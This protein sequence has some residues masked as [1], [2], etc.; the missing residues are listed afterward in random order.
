MNR[1]GLFDLFDV[2]GSG[3]VDLN[4]LSAGLSVL[5]GGGREEKVEA[6]FAMF[7]FDGNGFIDLDEMTT[8]L[9]SVFKVL[10]ATE[11]GTEEKMGVSSEEL[12][13]VTAEQ[14]FE[15][16]DADGDGRISL[17]EFKAWYA[18]PG[19]SAGFMKP[20]GGGGH[21]G[22]RRSGPSDYK[23]SFLH[24]NHKWNRALR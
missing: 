17:E 16:A 9:S 18:Q 3:A 1:L 12:A 11:P 7:D 10:Y 20:Q 8:Y 5:C 14:A 24:N 19:G 15:E 2:D 23:H 4:E 6:A 21:G 13:A 22:H